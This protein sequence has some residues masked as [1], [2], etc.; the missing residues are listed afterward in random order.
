MINY[1]DTHSHLYGEQYDEDR[2]EV[3]ARMHEA[4]VATLAVGVSFE[5]SVQAIAYA[6]HY[7]SVLGAVIG[8]HPTDTHELFIPEQFE[9]ILNEHVVAVGECGL[10]YFHTSLAEHI[11]RQNV[12]LE[13]QINFAVAHN[14]PL[15]LHVRPSKGTMDAHEE[16][17]DILAE[18]KRVHGDRVRGNVHFFTGT[19]A[20]AQDY[21]DLGF[22]ISFPGVVTFAEETHE[23][24]RRVPLNMMLA[25]TDA[26]YAAPVPHRGK[27][28]EPAFVVDTVN[29][30]AAIRGE[31]ETHVAAQLRD[32][33]IAHF[34]LRNA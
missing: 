25:E 22:K 15:M 7:D 21:L 29:A 6:Q 10:D 16:M 9:M 34:G 12:I 5:T 23:A 3:F 28:N 14:L 13:H 2:D 8:V 19:A 26:P 4:G 1:I 11:A 27:R 17:L 33:T 24:V 18:Q 20:I 30:I 32:N 31:D